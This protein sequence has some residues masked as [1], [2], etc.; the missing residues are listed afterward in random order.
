MIGARI[1][2]LVIFFIGFAMALAGG[3]W[4]GEAFLGGFIAMAGLSLWPDANTW[5]RKP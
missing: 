3:R 4:S 5:E 1:L 2:S